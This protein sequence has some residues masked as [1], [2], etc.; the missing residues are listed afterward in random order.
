MTL[1]SSQE[2]VIAAAMDEWERLHQPDPEEGRLKTAGKSLATAI[3]HLDHCND[4]IAQAADDVEGIPVEDRIASFLNEIG[5][6][7]TALRA[8]QKTLADGYQY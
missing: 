4:W 2:P 3:E 7:L 8:M 1:W 6:M 5:E